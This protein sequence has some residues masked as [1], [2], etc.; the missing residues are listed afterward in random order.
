LPGFITA[1]VVVIVILNVIAQTG[2]QPQPN[3]TRE[4]QAQLE[5]LDAIYAH[6]NSLEDE[7]DRLDR[8]CEKSIDRK[9]AKRFEANAKKIDRLTEQ[10]ARKKV[11]IAKLESKLNR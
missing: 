4:T 8:E 11:Q 5:L 3:Q 9:N 1:I 7:R 10:I 6:V 2:K